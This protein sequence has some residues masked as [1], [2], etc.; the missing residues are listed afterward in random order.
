MGE[1][2]VLAYSGGLDTTVIIPWL[3]EEDPE[4][5]IIAVCVDVGQ[6][7]ETD[8]LIERAT[9]IGAAKCIVLDVREEFITNYL[10]PL[11]KSGAVY[12]DKYLLGTSVARPLIAKK[13]VEIALAEKAD[14]LC[15][16]CT[17]KGNDQ[18]RFELTI[19]AFAPQLKII[20][21]WREWN[22]QSR[23]EELRYLAARG[24][25]AP[26]KKDQSYSRDRNLWH[27]SHEGLELEDPANEPDYDHLLTLSVPPEKAPDTPTYIELEFEQGVPVKLDGEALPP[28]AL[29]DR[30]NKLG[31]A[32]GIGI[33]DM[34]ENRVVGMKSRG[35]YETPGGT[36]LMKAHRELEFLCL[37]K[38]TTAYKSVA[39]VKYAEL[40][41]SG[42]WFTP[43]FEA[44]SAFFDVTQQTVTG[45]VRLKLY[46]GNII[47]AGTKSPFS[48][49][50]ENIAS[51][52]TGD[53]YDHHDANGFIKLFGLPLTVRAMMKAKN[54]AG[55]G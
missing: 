34:V 25:P 43:L 28:V 13:L 38:Q 11:V 54:E 2:I 47:F 22:L 16:G 31:G 39:C 36:I 52:T 30:L 55:N 46:K 20:A 5:E 14:A 29:M 1:K 18:I 4:R 3:K 50:N 53:L 37:D 41:Y 35:I 27:I 7:K 24:I 23:E 32:N 17:G 48:L 33:A 51:F 19:K 42:E 45:K 26:M 40:I 12:E 6:G 9:S 49:Y 44:L 8:G 15:H 21:P 10:Y